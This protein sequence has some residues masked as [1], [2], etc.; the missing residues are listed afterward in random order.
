MRYDFTRTANLLG[1]PFFSDWCFTIISLGSTI[2]TIISLGST[3]STKLYYN[4]TKVKCYLIRQS[5]H[6]HFKN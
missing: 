4:T 5:H 1:A 2:L 6:A 3:I